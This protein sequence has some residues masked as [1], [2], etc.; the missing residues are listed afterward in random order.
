MFGCRSHIHRKK[1]LRLSM[2]NHFLMGGALSMDPK[3]F[4][5]EVNG[6]F[7]H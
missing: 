4:T 7:C 6:F 5:N 3:L 1:F 2:R